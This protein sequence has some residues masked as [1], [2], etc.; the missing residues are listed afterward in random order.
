MET[1]Q[2]APQASYWRQQIENALLAPI[3]SMRLVYL[4]LLMVYFAYWR[5]W[6][7]GRRARLLDQELLTGPR[8]SWPLSACGYA[9]VTIK[10]V[11]ASSSIRGAFGSRRRSYV[12][13]AQRSSRSPSS[14]WRAAAAG[15]P[16]CPRPA[17][18]HRLADQRHRHRPARRGG[19]R[20]ST[21]LVPRVNADGSPGSSE[22][23][24]DLG[25]VQV[26]GRLALYFGIS[27]LPASPA[28][29]RR[30]SR[31]QGFLIG[32]RCPLISISVH[33]LSVGHRRATAID[34][35][36][37]GGGLVFGAVVTLLGVTAV[38][39]GQGSFSLLS[40]PSY[41]DAHAR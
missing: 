40:R 31:T 3:R 11:F 24:H 4:P 29:W 2:S 20:L 37:L 30:S 16:S 15:S 14:C 38:P 36:I 21:E 13:A 26:L 9:A 10:M 27:R 23:D 6:P 1:S 33:C 22:I 18:C 41:L 5:H 39:F 28:C 12:F 25:M 32:P 35:R 8:P 19:G 17:L 34:W 7:G